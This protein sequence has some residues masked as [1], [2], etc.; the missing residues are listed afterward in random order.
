MVK[1]EHREF[2]G[3]R[4]QTTQFPAMRSFRLLTSLAKQVG[5]VLGALGAL[6]PNTELSDPG[7]MEMLMSV[8]GPALQS[9]DPDAASKLLLEILANTTA[10]VPDA[11]G[12]ERALQFLGPTAAGNFDSVFSSR[13]MTMFKV[14]GFV[15]QVN[16]R[17]FSFGGEPAAPDQK[18]PE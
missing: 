18:M 12:G 8:L 17:D 6:D 10:I 14:I 13:L 2:D 4:F 5:P 1:T 7:N 15:L 9:L 11:T 3:I 16:Y